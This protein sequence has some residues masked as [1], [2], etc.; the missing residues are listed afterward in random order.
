MK[1]VRLIALFTYSLKS[2][3]KKIKGM[4]EREEKQAYL[5]LIPLQAV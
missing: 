3:H 1:K 2:S 5:G 4:G